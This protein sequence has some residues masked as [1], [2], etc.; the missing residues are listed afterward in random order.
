MKRSRPL[1]RSAALAPWAKASATRTRGDHAD[2]LIRR[3]QEEVE[4]DG[5]IV[6]IPLEA[7]PRAERIMAQFDAAR[8]RRGI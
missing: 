3:L 1:R 6:V 4:E 2:V 7:M 8:E 5:P